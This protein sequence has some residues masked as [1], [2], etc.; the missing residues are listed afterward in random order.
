MQKG[1]SRKA[2]QKRKELQAGGGKGLIK[3]AVRSE[4]AK[5]LKNFYQRRPTF[6]RDEKN[7]GDHCGEESGR[8]G[9]C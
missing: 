1:T 6:K 9:Q 3:S 7:K 4:G 8:G 2:N 5:I